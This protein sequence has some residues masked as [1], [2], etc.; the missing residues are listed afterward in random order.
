MMFSH[1]SNILGAQLGEDPAKLDQ[2]NKLAR[3]ETRS[4]GGFILVTSLS[5]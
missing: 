2:C 1:V 5:L 4:E 3:K